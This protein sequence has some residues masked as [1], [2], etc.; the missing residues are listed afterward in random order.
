MSDKQKILLVGK[1][2]SGKSLLFNRCSG[3]HQK[4]ANYAGATV[5]VAAGD[6]DEFALLDFPG[7]YSMRPV[8]AEEEVAVEQFQKLLLDSHVHAVVCVLDATQLERSLNFGIQIL[9]IVRQRSV[10]VV[11]ALNMYDD[12]LKNKL[13]IDHQGLERELLSPVVPISAKTGYGIV[14][15]KNRVQDPNIKKQWLQAQE[16]YSSDTLNAH[17]LTKKY[18]FKSDVL[19]TK[20]KKIDRVFLSG[21]LGAL[22]FFSIMFFIF[23]AIFTWALPLMDATEW[24]ITTLGSWL[25]SFLPVGLVKDF[26][27]DAIVGGLGSFIVFVP[28]IFILTFIIGLL[29]DSGYLSRVA[30]I[31]HRPLRM[32]GLS[33][34]SFIPFLSGHAC[35][36]PAIYAAR[37]IDSP[38]VRLATI[39]TIPLISC[40][41]RLPI[42]SLFVVALFPRND[43]AFGFF[44]TQGVAFFCLYLFGYVTAM[45]VSALITKLGSKNKKN[46]NPF[47]IELPAYRL[48]ILKPLFHR[49]VKSAW[50]FLSE[51]GPIIFFTSLVVWALGYFPNGKGA[52]E[53]SWLAGLGHAIQ[54]LLDPL[55]LDWKFG[56]AL[57]TSFVAREVFVSTLGTLN[58]IES[59]EENVSSLADIL[60]SGGLTFASGIALLVFYSIALQCVSTLATIKR[61]TKSNKIP[62]LLFLAYTGLAYILAVIAHTILN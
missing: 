2:N 29:E 6:W 20:L 8:S 18:G 62:A 43:Y 44:S 14:E 4:V 47:I 49:S 26:F 37:M 39:L 7:A 16:G 15:L 5:A 60:N 46:H 17:L 30:V 31:C 19:L 52:L 24:I 13:S 38:R 42:Y 45:L 41:A 22:L 48:P 1:P 57:L 12:I 3:L 32:F 59:A 21:A 35:A 9:E 61:E 34:K 54:P 10:P 40:S 11:F 23:Q 51:A 58:G 25:A 33:G 55:G 36:I 50:N 27:E 28:Q 56:V 53:S